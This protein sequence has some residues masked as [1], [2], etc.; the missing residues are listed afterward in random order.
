[1]V[2]RL[3]LMSDG[4]TNQIARELL[5]GVATPDATKTH[6]PFRH[7]DLLNGVEET[8][9]RAGLKT[10]HEA[11]ALSPDGLSYFGMLQME[12][13]RGDAT[14]MFPTNEESSLIIGLRNNNGKRFPAGLVAGNGTTVCDNL[15]FYGEIK[16]A[17]KH[18]RFIHRDLPNM[19]E[20]AVGMIGGL[21]RSMEDRIKAYKQYEIGDERAHDII[22]RAHD[23][24]VISTT[25][26][27]KV[28]KEWREPRHP[29][30][31]ERTAY[32]LMNAFTEVCK[33]QNIME[34]PRQT[35]ALA[36]ILDKECGLVLSAN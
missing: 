16:L 10:V 34:R 27:P 8:L 20:R 24:R 22:I 1:M 18:T 2:N 11:H 31:K 23:A 29:E 9:H 15:M 36:G 32:S 30:F 13:L 28:V 17:R 25:R 7:D 5:A 12:D 3:N 14:E 19:I 26:I 6:V 33:A 35:T 21:R 4:S